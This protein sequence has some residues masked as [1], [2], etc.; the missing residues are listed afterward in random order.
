[1]DIPL[2]QVARDGGVMAS[3]VAC[4]ACGA[5]HDEWVVEPRCQLLEAREK[6]RLAA[7]DLIHHT[8]MGNADEQALSV[9]HSA[10]AEVDRL[11]GE[12]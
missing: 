7:R 12:K 8:Y 2:A 6:E 5:P 11:E 9:Y 1:M 3:I 4:A 10:R